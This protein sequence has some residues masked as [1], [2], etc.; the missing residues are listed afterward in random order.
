MLVYSK[1][2]KPMISFRYCHVGDN[3]LT[4]HGFCSHAISRIVWITCYH[5]FHLVQ[6]YNFKE[7]KIFAKSLDFICLHFFKT[8]FSFF[9]TIYPDICCIL[10]AAFRIIVSDKRQTVALNSHQ[11]LWPLHHKCNDWSRELAIPA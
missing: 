3:F 4:P 8:L 7:K 11:L 6:Y 1:Y 2:W 9:F 5:H 10:N